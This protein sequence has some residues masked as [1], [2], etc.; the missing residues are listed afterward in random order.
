VIDFLDSEPTFAPGLDTEL[1]YRGSLNYLRRCELTDLVKPEIG[2]MPDGQSLGLEGEIIKRILIHCPPKQTKIF[3]DIA[4]GNGAFLD[5]LAEYGFDRN[6]MIGVNKHEGVFEVKHSLNSESESQFHVA[7]AERLPYRTDSVDG[8][9]LQNVLYHIDNP[10]DAIAELFRVLKPGGTAI[11]AGRNPGHHDEL[12][13]RAIDIVSYLRG[14]SNLEYAGHSLDYSELNAPISYYQNFDLYQTRTSLEE[15]GF[16]IVDELMQST[17]AIS[18][19][20][21][22]NSRVIPS[23]IVLN[24]EDW[25]IFEQALFS[26]RDILG[27]RGQIPTQ[28]DYWTAIQYMAKPIFDKITDV[29]SVTDGRYHVGIEQGF[30]VC[31][32]PVEL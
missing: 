31:K 1:D 15:A 11:V 13:T 17:A 30:F 12:W 3:L 24:R 16:V 20:E 27:N 22:D 18:A 25:D 6:N 8:L 19:S 2:L 28:R 7:D 21:N 4:C 9:T 5:R 14:L 10:L 32:K 26:L 29:A 23:E